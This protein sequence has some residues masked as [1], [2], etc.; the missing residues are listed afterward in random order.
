MN[1]T[2]IGDLSQSLLFRTRAVELKLSIST[3]TNELSS[4]QVSDP[5]KHL[6]GEYSHLIDIDRNLARL[7]GYS[8]AVSE[9][10][11]FASATQS[12]LE[13]MQAITES[14]IPQM[15][16]AIPSTIEAVHNN[17]SHQA[18]EGL[19]EALSLLN[20]SVSGRSLFAG[21]TTDTV[22]LGSSTLLLN[23]LKSALSGLNSA[24]DIIQAAEDWF[25]DPSGFSAIMYNGSEQELSPIQVG[26]GQHVDLPL[27]ADDPEFRDMLRNFAL[28]TLATDPELGLD[29][30]NRKALLEGTTNKMLQNNE[31]MTQIRAD[32]GFAESRIEDASTRNETSRASFEYA[33]GALLEADPFEVATRLESVQFQ[34]EA[35]YAVTVRTSRLSLLAF[36]K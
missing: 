12:R 5:S 26:P 13:R 7:E 33:R 36:L 19:D 10:Q 8:L 18:R 27:K 32:L 24:T 4:G 25:S 23:Q 28:T 2:S 21:V 35:L 11:V 17:I 15:L 31:K 9:A 6:G 1:M 29:V 16:V 20:G 30:E 34:L 22:P 14:L 3:L